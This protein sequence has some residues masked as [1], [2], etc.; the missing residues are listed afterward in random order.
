MTTSLYENRTAFRPSYPYGCYI[1]LF[2]L[3][4]LGFAPVPLHFD[5]LVQVVNDGVRLGN[6]HTVYPVRLIV[7][8]LHHLANRCVRGFIRDVQHR[9]FFLC[10]FRAGENDCVL[11]SASHTSIANLFVSVSIRKRTW[12]GLLSSSAVTA[13]NLKYLFVMLTVESLA[14]PYHWTSLCLSVLLLQNSS[15]ASSREL[16]LIAQPTRRFHLCLV[17]QIEHQI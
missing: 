13:L 14:L 3:G 8:P 15:V 12:V 2:L 9:P 11:S 6:S 10:L 4:C 16:A 5:H 1:L 17:F 7:E